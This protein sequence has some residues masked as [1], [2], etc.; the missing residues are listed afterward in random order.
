M[1]FFYFLMFKYVNYIHYKPSYIKQ[2]IRYN[3]N[4]L[5]IFIEIE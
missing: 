2:Y 4:L 5:K 3:K 1:L